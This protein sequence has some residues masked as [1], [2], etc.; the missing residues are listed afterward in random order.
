MSL[1]EKILEALCDCDGCKNGRPGQHWSSCLGVIKGDEIMRLVREHQ[2]KP[3][4]TLDAVFDSLC[5]QPNMTVSLATWLS[6]LAGLVV[7]LKTRI[8]ALETK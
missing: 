7:Q 1:Q 2:D 6:D 5:K 3:I 8:E 4:A